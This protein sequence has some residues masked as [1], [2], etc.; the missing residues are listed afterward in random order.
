MRFLIRPYTYKD[1]QALFQM[2]NSSSIETRRRV[3]SWYEVSALY[4]LSASRNKNTYPMIGFLDKK[5]ICF[6]KLVASTSIA[7]VI[8]LIV[9]DEHQ[10]KGF[11]TILMTI[12]KAMA[13]AK[14]MKF[15]RLEVYKTNKEGIKFY[16][17]LGFKFKKNDPGKNSYVMEIKL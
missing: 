7:E 14:G 10:G 2:I 16:R 4:K 11:G 6:G 17:K 8:G 5:A 1:K 13:I 15:L 12:L 3:S 9:L